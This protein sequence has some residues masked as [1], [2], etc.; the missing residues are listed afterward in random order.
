MSGKRRQRRT[1]VTTSSDNAE[2][3]KALCAQMSDMSDKVSEIHT[4]LV[5]DLDEPG[6]NEEHRKLATRVTTLE[7]SN[8]TKRKALWALG[9]GLIGSW[10]KGLFNV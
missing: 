6:L 9:V 1:P 2:S 7:K 3:L 10:L 8:E 5:G 4:H